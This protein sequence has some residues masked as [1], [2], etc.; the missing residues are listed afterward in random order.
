M[1]LFAQTKQE[2]PSM[3]Q[4]IHSQRKWLSRKTSVVTLLMTC[5][6]LS[7]RAEYPADKTMNIV[8]PYPAGG[9]VD[10][11][12]RILGESLNKKVGAVVV[13]ENRA[14]AAGTIGMSYLA[15]AKPDGYTV[16]VGSPGNISIAPSIYA[17]LPYQPTKSLTA[18]AQVVRMPLL[19]VA[20]ADAPFATTEQLIA[21]A[22]KNPGQLSYG[23]GG[24][25]SSTH[26]VGEMFKEMASVQTLHVPYTGSSPLM[27]D[28]LAGRIDY[29]FTD[30]SSLPNIKGGKL[31]LL[32]VTTA[33]RSKLL[34]NTPTVS[35]GGVTRFEALNWYGLFVPAGADASIVKK[36]NK[37]AVDALTDPKVVE[38]LEAQFMETSAPMAPE[39]FAEFVKADTAKWAL[40][41]RN[42]GIKPE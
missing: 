22:K 38:R 14:G 2:D 36:L 39:Q 1:L 21:Y 24:N 41:A 6:V 29:A 11:V 25:G 4:C 15:R 42:A 35:E 20:R 7:A 23:S 18:V 16:A 17:K 3:R 8:V 27:T 13:V 33:A 10:A 19:L 30:T 40:V 32:A 34:P 5:A 28:L 31:K 37:I 9:G 12:G 26:L